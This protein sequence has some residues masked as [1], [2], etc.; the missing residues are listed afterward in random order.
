VTGDVEKVP[1]LS[2]LALVLSLTAGLLG[3]GAAAASPA[4]AAAP[5]LRYYGAQLHALWS[6]NTP[7]DVSRQLDLLAG[8]HANSARVDVAWS[9]LQTGGRG[10]INTSYRD[11]IDQLVAGARARGISLVLTLNETPCW[12]SAAPASLKL[13]C[14]GSYWNRGVTRYPPTNV[15][16]YAWAARWVAARYG[17]RVAALEL[18]NEPNYN[19]DGYSPLIA[20]DRAATYAAMV[21]AAYPA[22]KAAAPALPV[23]VGAL[24]FGDDTFLKALYA[25]GIGRVHDGISVHP[26]NEWRAPGA[27]HDARY[28]M[29]DYVQGLTAIHAAMLAAG[30]RSPVWITELGWTT[31]ALGTGRWCVTQQQQASYVAAAATMA[32]RWP[33]VR[34]FIAYNLRDKGTN[35]ADSEHNFG[36]V[37]RDYTPKPA[38]STLRTA[39]AALS[40]ASATD[41]AAASAMRLPAPTPLLWRVPLARPAYAWTPPTPDPTG[42]APAE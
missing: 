3:V 4:Q 17:T 29:Y 27:A 18:W 31:C 11:R 34:A 13:A 23:L 22:A 30:D 24:S 42:S 1:R 36:L 5:S 7:A 38:L 9:S 25:R 6:G 39:F 32:A 21:R 40:V 12:A 16:D 19:H 37:R 15:A 14:T 8:M 41:P 28:Y 33:W 10:T 2:R 20:T 26:Y 35:P